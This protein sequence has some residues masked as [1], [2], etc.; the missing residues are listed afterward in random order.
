GGLRR[1]RQDGP[2]RAGGPRDA[3]DL[4]EGNLRAALHGA[5]RGRA[6]E[7]VGEVPV[8][9]GERR[10]AVPR[11]R[12]DDHGGRVLAKGAT[13][14]SPFPGMDPYLENPAVWSDFHSTFLMC[15]RAELNKI[16]PEHYVARWDRHVWVDEPDTER[17]GPLGRPDVFV[18]DALGRE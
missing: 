5:R 10:Q 17:R 6:R 15:I 7:A 14:P 16:L 8:G 2:P 12:G 1:L 18:T 4:D 3:D 13:M 11:L 9:R